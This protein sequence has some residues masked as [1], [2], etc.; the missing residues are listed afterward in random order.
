M[1]SFALTPLWF[2]ASNTVSELV[3]LQAYVTNVET[4]L[5]KGLIGLVKPE[6]FI[7]YEGTEDEHERVIFDGI[8]SWD[9]DVEGIYKEH[10]P[11]LHRR[12]VLLTLC[13]WLE[14]NLEGL[15]RVFQR[16]TGN[17]LAVHDLKH[18]GIGRAL[19]YL[20]TVGQLD[21]DNDAHKTAW[22]QVK[23]IY[24]YRNKIA[25]TG[26]SLE[27]LKE[28]HRKKLAKTLSLNPES[29]EL[30]EMSLSTV[31]EAFRTLLLTIRSAIQD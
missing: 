1:G 4:Q 26:G 28:Q 16:E 9:W 2:W 29:E 19:T 6:K 25:H 11:R 21:L 18:S 10:F 27:G 7:A 17:P 13:A 12:A 24:D 20:K 30:T 31:I 8:D 15:C 14:D 22:Q 23:L 3:M 5:A